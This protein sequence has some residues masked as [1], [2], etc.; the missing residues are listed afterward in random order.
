MDH[1]QVI[2]L[3]EEA[4]KEITEDPE[5]NAFAKRDIRDRILLAHTELDP[6]SLDRAID[7]VWE[8]WAQ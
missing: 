8:R 6:E 7:A 5:C 2:A 3:V 1:S 4:V